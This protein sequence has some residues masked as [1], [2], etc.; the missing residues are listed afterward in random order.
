MMAHE[1]AVKNFHLPLPEATYDE[2]RAEAERAQIPAT[3]I[4]RQAIS[5]WLRAKKKAARR[6]AVM[7]YAAEMA[8]T[9][10][11]LDPGLESAAI[12]ELVRLDREAK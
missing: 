2:L 8:G 9:R 7:E 1:A 11:D 10:F 3:T 6:K 5:D 4:A 12:E